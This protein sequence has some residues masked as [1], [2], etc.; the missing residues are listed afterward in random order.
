M[1]SSRERWLCPT[2]TCEDA[3]E[4]ISNYSWVTLKRFFKQPSINGKHYREGKS[5]WRVVCVEHHIKY[6]SYVTSL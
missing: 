5:E 3:K 2:N 6:L 1:E 4:Q